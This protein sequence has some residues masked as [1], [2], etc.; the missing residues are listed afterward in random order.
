[1]QYF[2]DDSSSDDDDF[3][4]VTSLLADI[5]SNKCLKHGGSVLGRVMVRCRGVWWFVGIGRKA[6][7]G[8]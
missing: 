2:Y 6:M 1:M 7:L 4:I 5:E 8:L 3:E